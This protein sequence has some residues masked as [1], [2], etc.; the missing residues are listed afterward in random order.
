MLGQKR[1]SDWPTSESGETIKQV[2]IVLKD[3]GRQCFC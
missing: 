1:M 2:G 3:G